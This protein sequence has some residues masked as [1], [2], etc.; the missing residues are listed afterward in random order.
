MVTV[1]AV[2][3]LCATAVFGTSLTHLVSSPEL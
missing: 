1:A 2:G 3:A